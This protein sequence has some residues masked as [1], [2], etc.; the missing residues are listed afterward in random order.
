MAEGGCYCGSVRYEISGE[1]INQSIC[2]CRD[3][4][5]SSGAASVAWIMLDQD[6][7]SL[8][9]GALKT[10]DGQGGAERHFCADCGT[11]IAYKNANIL[12]GMIDVQTATLDQPDNYIPE[13]NIQT[14]EQ[15][16]WEKV[17]HEMPSF[18]RFPPQE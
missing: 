7:F 4:Q 12:P 1:P 6:E 18:D 11:G 14:A 5:K 10:V 16:S 15:I 8:T 2:H 9:T 13:M 17:A 3:C